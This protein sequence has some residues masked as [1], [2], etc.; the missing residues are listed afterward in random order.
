MIKAGVSPIIKYRT[1]SNHLY[2]KQKEN[3]P[4]NININI[5]SSKEI[6][7]STQTIIFLC[8]SH[9]ASPFTIVCSV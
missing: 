2:L 1:V 9:I 7:I 5:F 3:K 8:G 6:N 4:I